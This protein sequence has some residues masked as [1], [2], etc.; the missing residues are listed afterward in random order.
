VLANCAG[1][2]A[3]PPMTAVVE[4]NP[5][6]LTQAALKEILSRQAMALQHDP[7][8][9][10]YEKRSFRPAWSGDEKD[11]EIARAALGLAQEQGLKDD[12]YRLPRSSAAKAGV[13]AA[14]Y[15][16]A[17]TGAVLRY[18]HD[19]R[20]GRIRPNQVYSDVELPAPAFDSAGDLTQSLS[21]NRLADFFVHL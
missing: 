5:S 11:Q 4:E 15:D 1:M 20:N 13:D 18:A 3:P 6:G 19:V 8:F 12:D 21:Q 7:L 14:Q 2:K 10:F 17:I 16:I 9:A